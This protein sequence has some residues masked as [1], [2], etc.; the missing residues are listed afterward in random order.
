MH[1]VRLIK[2][3][4]I[5]M[6]IESLT[7]LIA[8]PLYRGSRFNMN[9]G[10]LQF[11]LNVVQQKVPSFKRRVHAVVCVNPSGKIDILSEFYFDNVR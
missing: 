3:D 9:C 11:S 10:I 6:N 4:K 7:I 5:T 1:Y 2:K 8:F